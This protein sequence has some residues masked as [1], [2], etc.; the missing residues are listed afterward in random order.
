MMLATTPVPVVIAVGVVALRIRS[1]SPGS[2]EISTDFVVWSRAI[3]VTGSGW[4]GANE[5]LDDDRLHAVGR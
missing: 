2:A 5:D 4:N 3:R 1:E